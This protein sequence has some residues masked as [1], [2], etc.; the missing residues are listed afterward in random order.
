MKASKPRRE[1][2]FV[3]IDENITMDKLST[4]TTDTQIDFEPIFDPHSRYEA[5]FGLVT[6]FIDKDFKE[7]LRNLP[8]DEREEQRLA[9]AAGQD[10]FMAGFDMGNNDFGMNMNGDDLFVDLDREFQP[11][12]MFLGDDHLT[13]TLKTE[14]GEGQQTFAERIA[15]FVPTGK[16]KASKVYFADVVGKLKSERDAAD[17][18]YDLMCAARTGQVQLKQDFPSRIDKSSRLPVIELQSAAAN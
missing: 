12:D 10:D 14:A 16:K 6:S 18:F 8:R 7:T 15:G 17:L 2:Q 13:T 5:E 4:S 11:Q 3:T 1:K 9:E